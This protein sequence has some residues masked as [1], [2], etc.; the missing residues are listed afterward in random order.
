[1]PVL[2]EQDSERA[3]KLAA[4]M[5]DG[6][7]V[8]PGI[9][10][11]DNWLSNRPEEFAV[12]LGPSVELE[13]A[14]GLADRMRTSHPSTALVLVRGHL[15]TD[16]FAA[17]MAAG[18]PAVVEESDGPSL[19]IAMNRARQTW[20]A[21]HGPAL[22]GAPGHE[23][24]VITVF[25]PKG[26]V[27]KTTMSVNIALALAEGGGTRVALVDL[28]L[29]FGDVAITLQLVPEH[30]IAE[31]VVDA[32]QLDF[33]LLA[34][35]LTRHEDSLM[36]LA[37]PT[38]P[39]AKDHIPAATVRRVIATLR[40]QFDYVVVDTAA[41]FEDTILQAFD[42]TDECVLVATLDVPT[43]KNMKMAIETLDLLNLAKDHRHLI[44]NRADDEVGLSPANVESIL[45]MPITAAIPTDM[46]V[47]NATNHGRPIVLSK[48]TH[49]VSVAIRELA[50]KVS[51]KDV[52]VAKDDQRRGLFGRQ[53]KH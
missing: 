21:L 33:A 3:T 40:S 19:T 48:P 13:G 38:V 17:A 6:T 52:A 7:H 32:G 49:R 44:L 37:A 29:A 20:E 45:K 43:V 24:K 10:Q 39:D 46:A 22:H 23:G 35:L 12:V 1:M 18:I 9:E 47:P 30:T 53:K 4:S 51:G 28:D 26:G 41:G 5:P 8:V 15:G 42:E 11:L 34:T 2:V 50:M 14:A 27:G 25:S 31:A 36:V 16:V